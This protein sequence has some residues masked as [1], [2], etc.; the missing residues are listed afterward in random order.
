MKEEIEEKREEGRVREKMK[1]V[2]SWR[3]GQPTYLGD[4]VVSR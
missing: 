3:V 1:G 4:Y 2:M